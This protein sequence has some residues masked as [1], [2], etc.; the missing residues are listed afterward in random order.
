MNEKKAY[1]V[2]DF[3][4][5]EAVPCPCGQSKRAFVHDDNRVASMHVVE[6]SKESRPHYHKKM[7]EIYYVLEGEGHLEIDKDKVPLKPG[8]S[9]LIPPN[10][11]HRAVGQ[12]KI[13]NVPIPAFDPVDEWFVD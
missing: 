12:L 13:I 4:E 8:V 1:L 2:A 5:I 9:V 11:L 3:D 10:S 7:T 6:I